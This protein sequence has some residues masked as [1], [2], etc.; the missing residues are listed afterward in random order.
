MGEPLVGAAVHAP[1]V[2]PM[3]AACA[4]W[5]LRGRWGARVGIAVGVT[6]VACAAALVHTIVV[7]GPLRYP[8]GGW[9]APLGIA[10]LVD[11]PAVVLVALC[12]VTG[13]GIS[14]HARDALHDDAADAFW[15][16]WLILWG[17]L[18]ALALAAD[19]F[20]LYVALELIGLPAV[21]LVAL[22]RGPEAAPAAERYV[23]ASLLAALAYL[24][25]VALMYAEYGVLDLELLARVVR[26]SPA[27][28]TALGLITGALALKA[29]LL[30]LHGWLPPAHASAPAPASAILSALV[31]KGA[32]LTLLRL[33]S[34]TFAP[35]RAP[36]LDAALALLGAV[37]ILGGSVLAFRQTRLKRVV[38]Y[39]TVAQLGYLFVAFGLGAP[40]PA[41][42]SGVLFFAVAHG[43][44]K[45]ALFLAAGNVQRAFG[46]D[47]LPELGGAASALPASFFA[48]AIA[49]VSISGLPPSGGFVAKWL[50]VGV[51]LDQGRYEL[52]AVILVGGL[53]SAGYLLRVVEAALAEP[54][55]SLA[56]V[57]P[58]AGMEGAAL[59][60][61]LA[62]LLLGALPVPEHV[63]VFGRV[64]P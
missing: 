22:G 6:L 62:A 35:I 48:L 38:A 21:A 25:A 36:A 49:A 30:P 32:F 47:R 12:A 51:A 46:H 64:P 7:D 53:L 17:G 24:L 1:I 44:A 50:L 39:S 14:V 18:G 10:L 61:A 13:V 29:A 37:A 58:P 33:L 31:V 40:T 4:A 63:A 3:A 59:A 56:V 43:L 26:P 28:W 45:S 19:L 52:V 57:R 23:L 54:R 27:T 15:P 16:L 60:L 34:T 2:V 9:P 11:W 41:L 8:V 55:A 5:V 20:T 42:L